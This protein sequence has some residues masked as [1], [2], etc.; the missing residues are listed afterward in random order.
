LHEFINILDPKEVKS[1][2]KILRMLQ[3][4]TF[5]FLSIMLVFFWFLCI[6]CF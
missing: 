6:I 3:V 1:N 4:F 5:S 2:T